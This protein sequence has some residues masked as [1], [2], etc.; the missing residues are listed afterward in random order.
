M[1]GPAARLQAVSALIRSVAT[2]RAASEAHAR[3]LAKVFGEGAK[4]PASAPPLHP[5]TAHLP[6]LIHGAI[7]GE[8][9]PALPIAAAGTMVHIGADLLDDL[10][11]GDG[12]P[13]GLSPAEAMLAGA[14]LVGP[15]PIMALV[16]IDAPE[17]ARLRMIEL[18]SEAIVV[19]GAGQ[20]SDLVRSEKKADL[21]EVAAIAALKSGALLSGLARMA[22]VL[23]NADEHRVAACGR[24]GDAIGTAA[25]LRADIVN[26]AVRLRGAPLPPA[27]AA[28]TSE[29]IVIGGRLA[30][31][32]YKHACDCLEQLQ[33]RGPWGAALQTIVRLSAGIAAPDARR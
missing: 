3:L 18:L 28:R 5:I 1:L 26:A 16:R 17:R 10:M 25:Q 6:C 8:E 20:A 15:L 12:A 9:L 13:D 22:A 4:R 23:A 11:D 19:M 32:C 24:L 31:V 21:G 29:L 2:E 33:P 30:Q 7:T 27:E 14:G